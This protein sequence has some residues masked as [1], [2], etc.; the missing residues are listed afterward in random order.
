LGVVFVSH[1]ITA[2]QA[3]FLQT[4][5]IGYKDDLDLYTYVRNG[6]TNKV[7]PTGKATT[8]N[9]TGPDAQCTMTADTFDPARSDHK[10]AI[11]SASTKAAVEQGK[12]KVAS[13]GDKE[14]VGFVR[15]GP[16]GTPTLKTDND[17][18][19]SSTTTANTASASV[20]K[21]ALAMAHGHAEIGP[22]ALKGMVDS[23]ADAGGY[24]DTQALAK[25]GIPEATVFRNDVGWH[26]IQD[27][28]LQ[29]TF[30]AG[31]LTT[32]QASS[33]Q[34]NLNVEQELFKVAAGTEK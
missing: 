28:Q 3:R 17:A 21:D 23:P 26:Q 4:D 34:S 11:P 15:P 31:A 12:D 8:C 29:F 7:D 22:S 14:K 16:D 27:G 30:R 20:P 10:T 25:S 5:P 24:G 19:T 18:T 9:G 6:P 1:F 13:A 2:A 32:G 33:M